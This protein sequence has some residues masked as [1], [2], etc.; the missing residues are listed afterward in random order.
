MRNQRFPRLLGR[1]AAL[2]PLFL[3]GCSILDPN[4]PT[5]ARTLDIA[6]LVVGVGVLII[7]GGLMY[8]DNRQ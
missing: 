6:A 5:A 4:D 3:A 2:L 8:H 1:L 7:L